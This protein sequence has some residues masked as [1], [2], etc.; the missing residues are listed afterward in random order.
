MDHAM[1]MQPANIVG[2]LTQQMNHLSLGT[3]GTVSGR[4]YFVSWDLRR[5]RVLFSLE[6]QICCWSQAA[7]VGFQHEQACMQVQS[8]GTLVYMGKDE[9]PVALPLDSRPFLLCGTVNQVHHNSFWKGTLLPT[10][11]NLSS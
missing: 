9:G 3:A 11:V 2:P 6:S 4:V 8:Q 1:S 10:H 7:A 5:H